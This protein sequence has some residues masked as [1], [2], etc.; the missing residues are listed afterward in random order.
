[1]DFVRKVQQFN[2]VDWRTMWHDSPNAGCLK[3]TNSP[4]LLSRRKK[5]EHRCFLWAIS[6]QF[7]AFLS[8]K[9]GWVLSPEWHIVII[10]YRKAST[11]PTSIYCLAY[12][13][14]RYVSGSTEENK[15]LRM[16]WH[17]VG[18]FPLWMIHFFVLVLSSFSV[19]AV[20]EKQ[21][22]V[23]AETRFR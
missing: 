15:R 3:V 12:D 18:G 10:S 6:C 20:R 11:R 23:Y 17:G 7:L 16:G 19:A 4:L 22:V 13:W 14:W 9:G 1:M 5:G 21:I 2:I 8:E